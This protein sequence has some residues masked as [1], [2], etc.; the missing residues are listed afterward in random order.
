MDIDDGVRNLQVA[1]EAGVL[2]A[3]PG[4]LGGF[5]RTA[6][7]ARASEG[8][9]PTL[10]APGGELRGVHPFPA[11]ERALLATFGTRIGGREDALFI[12]EGKAAAGRAL[13]NFRIRQR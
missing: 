10:L 12:G 9:V 13:A 7:G 11:Q 2:A 8:V 3:Q 6:T 1:G 5:P 4:E